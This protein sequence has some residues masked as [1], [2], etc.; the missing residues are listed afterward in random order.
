MAQQNIHSG[1]KYNHGRIELKGYTAVGYSDFVKISRE[2]C[3]SY[4]GKL[5]LV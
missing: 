2:V 4:E 1:E 3:T 5:N